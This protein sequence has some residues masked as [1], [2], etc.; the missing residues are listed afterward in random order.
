MR[1]AKEI[2]IQTLSDEKRENHHYVPIFLL[3]KWCS[4]T[5]KK[6]WW[7]R[8]V[9]P[10]GKVIEERISPKSTSF[11]P[12]LNMLRK[13]PF[14]GVNDKNLAVVEGVYLKK[15]DT[16][17][18]EIMKKMLDKGKGIPSLTEEERKVWLNFVILLSDRNPDNLLMA[19]LTGNTILDEV[20]DDSIKRC[21]HEEVWR[22]AAELLKKSEFTYNDSRIRLL[23]LVKDMTYAKHSD[24]REWRIVDLSQSPLELFSSNL[25]VV[26]GIKKRH[27]FEADFL[28]MALTPKHLWLCAPT[29]FKFDNELIRYLVITYNMRLLL[30]RPKYVYS[31]NKIV[32]EKHI[33]YQKALRKFLK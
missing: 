30:L 16:Q 25:P 22:K 27:S 4:G 7:Y 8:R 13:A 18:A 6:M 17:A 11:E 28:E 31:L 3:N 19:E 29:E 1:T 2:N 23:N 5:E 26:A 15:L 21:G 10:S 24:L 12:N 33:K 9:I 20:I 32:D 14:S